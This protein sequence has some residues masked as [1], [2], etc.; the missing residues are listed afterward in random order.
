MEK[1]TY[2]I[3]SE[4]KLVAML[5]YNLIGP[6]NSNRWLI[7]D[8]NNNQVGFIQ[9]KKLFNENVK[10]GYSKTYGY[11]TEIDSKDISYKA[12]RKIENESRKIGFDSKFRYEL[13]IRRG[14]GNI[15]H[16]DINVG[17]YPNLTLWSKEYGF[18]N[19]K[20][21][22]EG[23]YLNYKSKTENFNIE[24]TLVYKT[25][26]EKV[27][28]R[29]KEY[30]YQLRY[31]DKCIELNDENLKGI[32]I[33]EITGTSTPYQQN[34]NEMKL[35]ENTWI[36][37][38]LI[39][40]KENIVVGNVEEMAV[41]HGMGIDAF[42]HFRFLINQILPFKQEVISVMLENSLCKREELSLF[43]PE[44]G[45]VTEQKSNG[46]CKENNLITKMHEVASK[47]TKEKSMELFAEHE[48]YI[49][50]QMQKIAEEEYQSEVLE[51]L[52]DENY[53]DE[54]FNMILGQGY[55]TNL[56][57][58]CDGKKKKLVKKKEYLK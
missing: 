8:E 57:K 13:D 40:N 21:D 56:S 52:E 5:G 4:I 3:E 42:K 44:L 29:P 19:F 53:D 35:V 38:K 58:K 31:C 18:M 32:K 10:K 45:K 50:Q 25:D 12:T 30:S 26:G 54:D 24:E 6:N 2:D 46:D 28:K 20:V 33:C 27:S 17:D 22:Y 37:G 48:E 41:K 23:L 14:N 51:L 36:N 47:L 49:Q 39:I 7:V 16:I 11:H 34:Y 43:I 1:V 15:D 55:P 9:Y